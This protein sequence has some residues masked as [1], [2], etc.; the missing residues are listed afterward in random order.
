MSRLAG[1]RWC[2][3]SVRLLWRGYG[4]GYSAAARGLR[5][6]RVSRQVTQTSS[7]LAAS[8]RST[9]STSW[10]ASKDSSKSET[11]PKGR[12]SRPAT[13]C[14]GSSSDLPG[15]RDQQPADLADA[16]A[17]RDQRAPVA[18][19]QELVK[20]QNIPQSTLDQRP[21]DDDAAAKVMQTQA[22]LDQA[23]INLDYTD[24]RAPI[25]GES[26]GPT[27]PSATWSVPRAGPWR[28]SSARTR[29]T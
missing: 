25:D 9:R 23:Q 21:A 29:S 17:Q 7:S 11:S 19:R 4:P 5:G 20:N 28:P 12:R 16:K 24:I 6:P 15:E 10:R 3:G 1:R 14:S 26:G 27:S 13:S 8:R 2:A 18:A 22:L